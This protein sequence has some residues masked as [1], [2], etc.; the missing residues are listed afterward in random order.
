MS[1]WATTG[2]NEVVALPYIVAGTIDWGDSTPV[3]QIESDEYPSHTYTS[4]GNHTVAVSGF[5]RGVGGDGAA[6]D[7]S[8]KLLRIESWG[9]FRFGSEGAY[10]QGQTMLEG[11]PSNP[12]DMRAA[13]NLSHAFAGTS[14][15]GD[16]S[17]WDVE[18]VAHCSEFCA[19]CDLPAF[20]C[21][22]YCPD[23]FTIT[24][25]S[26][27]SACQCPVGQGP[28]SCRGGQSAGG[29]SAVERLAWAYAVL[30]DP[31]GNCRDDYMSFLG[32][33]KFSH[34]CTTEWF[35]CNGAMVECKWDASE[36]TRIC[37]CPGIRRMRTRGKKLL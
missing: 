29:Q 6:V 37:T 17:R 24:S 11:L 1:T 13:S 20:T 34:N 36:P 21:N 32:P 16:L 9:R 28:E 15:D 12:P 8:Q 31:G 3:E 23:N 10:F 2:A 35:I 19:H 27:N 26:G 22:D 25:S 33:N 4:A 18:L 30:D 7:N 5:V 14:F